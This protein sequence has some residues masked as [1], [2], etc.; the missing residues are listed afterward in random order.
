MLD[1][2]LSFLLQ[3]VIWF[4]FKLLHQFRPYTHHTSTSHKH[5]SMSQKHATRACHSSCISSSHA[6]IT[7]AHY[8][9]MSNRPY[10]HH[11]STSH[12][13]VTQAHHTSTRRRH[14]T[15]ACHTS[16]PQ[17]LHQFRPC[18][19]HTGTLHKHV[20]QAR[21]VACLCDMLV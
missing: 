4:N 1:K 8:T 13:H 15:Q 3:C 17:F 18:T 6:H 16:M 11:R 7:Q 10:A 14:V 21:T 20:K 9:S 19:H 12:K 2:C 5:I